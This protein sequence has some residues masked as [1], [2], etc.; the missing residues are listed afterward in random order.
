M[1]DEKKTI[2]TNGGAYI[3]GDVQAGQDF[4]GRDKIETLIHHLEQK[5]ANRDYVERQEITQV[6][7]VVP[8]AQEDVVKRL[9]QMEGVGK[10]LLKKLGVMVAPEHID[11]QI[12]E[13]QAAQKEAEASGVTLKPEGAYQLGMLAAYRRDYDTAL[14]YFRRAT[15]DDPEYTQAFSAI[16]WLQQSLAMGDLD[17]RDYES[18]VSKLKEARSA[19]SQTDPLD[20][21]GLATRGFIAKTLAQISDLRRDHASSDKYYDE[22]ARMFKGAL[23]L[24]SSEAGAWNG[25]GNVEYASGHLDAAIDAYSKAIALIPN[26]TAAYHDLAIAY[27]GKMEVDAANA[28]KWCEKALAAWRETY[29][30]APND[31]G[32]ASEKILWIGQ[33][34][35]RLEQQCE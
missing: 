34:I 32:F 31:P 23:Q 16:A 24:N 5:I 17:S 21:H 15:Q 2:H 30:L 27:M 6:F 8:G 19:A 20:A 11:R 10:E 26:Y 33:Q 14:D 29:H 3:E 7:L 12:E 35:I 13:V 1:V 28:D 18:A 22:A 25:L 9:T 4:V